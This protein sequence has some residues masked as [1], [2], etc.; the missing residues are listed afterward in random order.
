M[1]GPQ[2]GFAGN[3]G[4]GKTTLA[5][6]MGERLSL[7]V[8]HE[9]VKGNPFLGLFYQDQKEWAGWMQFYLLIERYKIHMEAGYRALNGRGSIVDRTLVE[10]AAFCKLHVREGNIH[11]LIW[12]HIYKPDYLKKLQREYYDLF[13][14]IESGQHMWSQ[15]MKVKRWQWNVDNQDIEPIAQWLE[16]EFPIL[17]EEARAP[18]DC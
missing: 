4:A 6:K 7:P 5:V 17:K 3:I 12:K 14:S 9:P 15:G 8:F 16:H 2:I 18:L 13:A 1:A 10:D 11:E